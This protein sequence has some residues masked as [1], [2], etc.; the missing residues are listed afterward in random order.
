MKKIKGQVIVAVVSV[1]VGC[2]RAA[3]EITDDCHPPAIIE[4][5]EPV[6]RTMGSLEVHQG[7]DSAGNAFQSATIFA[8]SSEPI[9]ASLGVFL[10]INGQRQNT[11]VWNGR[12]VGVWRPTQVDGLD[13]QENYCG[14][15]MG[16]WSIPVGFGN[17]AEDPRGSTD[18]GYSVVGHPLTEG[19]VLNVRLD[20]CGPQGCMEGTPKTLVVHLVP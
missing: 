3:P 14:N 12:V 4:I 2:R 13:L 20:L 16:F 19:Q 18:P 5:L 6:N 1:V 7:F 15:T 11:T 8:G 10:T 17:I 9:G